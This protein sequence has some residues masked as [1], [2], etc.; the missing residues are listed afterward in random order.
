MGKTLGSMCKDSS[1]CLNNE[2]S[3]TDPD[4]EKINSSDNYFK[5]KTKKKIN[6][7]RISKRISETLQP[8]KTEESLEEKIRVLNTNN[9]FHSNKDLSLNNNSLDL[10]S[11]DSCQT[12]K[13]EQ[14]DDI[15][16]ISE[17]KKEQE[18]NDINDIKIS[19]INSKNF[20]KNLWNQKSIR[21]INKFNR[22]LSGQIIQNEDEDEDEEEQVNEQIIYYEGEKCTFNGELNQK[23]PLNGKGILQLNNGEKLEGFFIDGKL[24]KY[25]KYTDQN[26]T[27]FEGEFQ[28]GILNGKGKIIQLKQN[29]N[30]SRSRDILNQITYNGDIKNFKKEGFGEEICQDYVYEGQFHKDKK[31][32]KGKIKYIQSGDKYEGDFYDGIINGYGKYEW[33]N[34][35][36]YIGNFLN[37][38]M[39]GKGLFKWPDGSEYEGDYV[40]G[41]REGLGKF[42]WSNGNTFKGVFKKGKPNGK[43]T[44]TNCGFSYQAEYKN[45]NYLSKKE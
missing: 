43:G 18:K 7:L 28:N 9:T 8:I 31:H 42:T 33:A 4:E 20:R 40:K 24:N 5:K 16:K 17:I 41:V 32:G 26:G 11:I 19:R 45:G 29:K 12:E 2:I 38:E 15:D 13:K 35:C 36:V 6:T 22:F 3:K 34:K 10:E 37:G 27:I 1:Y 23:E 39:D 44:V 30:K 21:S 14:E 25:G